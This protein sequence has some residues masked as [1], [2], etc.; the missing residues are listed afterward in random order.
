MKNVI[1]IGGGAAGLMAAGFAAGQGHSVLVV[2]TQPRP[3]RK[4]MITGKGR[5]NVT[6]NT[7]LSGLIRAVN[8]NGK[9]LYSAFSEWS[10]QD[11]MNFFEERGVPLKTERGNRVFPCSDKSV[12][13]VDALVSFAKENAKFI[14][15]RA[16]K[17]ETEENKVKSVCLEDG[18]V[19]PCDAVILSTGGLSYPLTGSTG[20]GYKIAKMLGHTVTPLRASLVGVECAE[21]FCT[22]L[23]GLSLK[24]VGIK[25]EKTGDKKP[26]YT[27]F[28]E[29]LFTHFGVSG[30][31]VLSA[32]SKLKDIENSEYILSIDLKPA[33]DEATLDARLL[34]DFGENIN[35]NLINSL[36]GLLPKKLIP[37][38]VSLSKI[39]P[40]CKVNQLTREQRAALISVLK[41]LKLKITALRPIEE[42][43]ITAGGVSLKEV[44][45]NNM[46][47]KLI[48]GL[49]FA[50][51]IL[52]LD[53]CTGGFNLQIAFST[54]VKAGKYI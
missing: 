21:G 40:E 7:D 15:G 1:V 2:E 29:L 10:A 31:T 11:T 9:F 13:I 34:R 38:V 18:S 26:V 5:C 35:K 42:A 19:L 46:H 54:G 14:T 43:V 16:V 12:D 24:N 22:H 53:A 8:G 51:E 52:D 48:E 47:S 39:N 27:D 36:D 17:I 44:N 28:G 6:N 30:P 45:P 50:G 25:L 20:D 3:A 32:S 23:A 37:V 4:I 33:L 41:G 49:S